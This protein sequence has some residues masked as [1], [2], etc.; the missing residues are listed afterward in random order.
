MRARRTPRAGLTGGAGAAWSLLLDQVAEGVAVLDA[1]DGRFTILETNAA[2]AR[3]IGA[4]ACRLTGRPWREAVPAADRA[5]EDLFRQVAAGGEPAA[6]RRFRA[7]PGEEGPGDALTCR[8]WRCLPLR[9]GGGA[10]E[11]LLVV[12]ADATG[13]VL[14]EGGRALD[15]ALLEHLPFGLAILTGAEQTVALANAAFARLAG[16]APEDLAGRPLRDAL[17]AGELAAALERAYRTGEPATADDVVL[18]TPGGATAWRFTL[19]PVPG[20]DGGVAGLLAMAVET[21]DQVRARRAVEDL[22]AA[23]RQRAGQLEAIIGSMVDGVFIL[24]EEGLVVEANAV[25]L[26]LLGLSPDAESRRLSDYL[27][28]LAPRLGDGRPL[29]PDAD[30]LAGVRAGR[31]LADEELFL[32]APDG[33]ERAVSLGGAPVREADGRVGGMVVLLR[34]ISEQKRAEQEKDAFFSLISHE[35][36]SPLTA[37]KGYAQLAERAVAPGPAGERQSR[38]LGV[39]AEQVARI[40]RLVEDL[41]EVNRLRSGVL[42]QEPVDFDLAALTRATVERHRVTVDTHRLELEVAAEPLTVHADPARIEQVLANLLTNAVKYSPAADRVWVTLERDG[43][44]AHL[45]VRDAGIGIPRAEQARLFARFYR[46]S[47][48]AEAGP[49]GLG[50]GL[51]IAH[52]IVAHSGGRIWVESAEGQG[53]TF[54]VMLPLAGRGP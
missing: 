25:G 26:A 29:P 18:R 39:V 47:N 13:A 4:G 30:P 54:H 9:E 15:L 10:V 20:P 42:R 6:E 51:F 45:H 22:A 3:L 11:R 5:L 43:A 1:R 27:A 50:L 46:G 2:F 28:P 14:R 41:S 38:Y 35:V 44:T 40:E 7:A 53:S 12:V 16:V 21:T 31:V 33:R 23:A 34:D 37:I 36:K 24:D 8:D 19:A 49:G 32:T 52:E 17:P 48:A